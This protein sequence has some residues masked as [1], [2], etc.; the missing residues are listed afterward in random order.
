MRKLPRA[1]RIMGVPIRPRTGI[2]LMKAGRDISLKKFVPNHIKNE[3]LAICQDCE[4]WSETNHRCTECGCQ[5]RVK[6]SLCSSR[7]PLNKW[8]PYIA[9]PE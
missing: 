2:D 4:H 9:K 6:A 3:R 1:P 5:M 7:C 8:G